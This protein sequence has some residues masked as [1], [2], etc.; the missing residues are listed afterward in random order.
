MPTP[1]AA[2]EARVNAVVLAKTANTTA[3]I[4]GVEVD[5]VFE[6]EH[7]VAGGGLGMA[8]TNPRFTLPTDRVPEAPEGLQ[9]TCKND[10]YTVVEHE[11]DGTGLSVLVLERAS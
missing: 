4:G 8:M 6:N 10:L 11:P 3:S 1:F 9:I 2:L 5:G 7:A